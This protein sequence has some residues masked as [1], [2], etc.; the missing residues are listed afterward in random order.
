MIEQQLQPRGIRDAR[1]LEAMGEIPRERFVPDDLLGLAYS[2]QAL[3]IGLGQTISQPYIVAYMTQMLEVA[4]NHRVL[5]IGTGSGYQTAIL[6]R[7]CGDLYTI[8][9][10]HELSLRSQ[11]VL[12]VLGCRNVHFRVGDGTL[13]WPEQAPFDRIMVT[14]AS[15][16]VPDPLLKQ[17]ADEGRLI[18]PIG[19]EGCQE[20][21]L[22]EKTPLG[23]SERR[24]IGCRFVKLLGRHGWSDPADPT[25][26]R[27][28]WG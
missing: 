3:S 15:P 5:E 28:Q 24:L 6:S 16:Q 18:I 22:Y 2:D 11:N 14:A 27:T 25:P 12:Q 4:A 10:L 13:G 9:T 8:E 23:V 7:L 21:I 20:L 19:P 26:S 1:I 17:L